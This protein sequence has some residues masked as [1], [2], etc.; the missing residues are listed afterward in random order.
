MKASDE[1]YVVMTTGGG[2]KTPNPHKKRDINKLNR[3]TSRFGFIG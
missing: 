2:S 3:Q 1:E